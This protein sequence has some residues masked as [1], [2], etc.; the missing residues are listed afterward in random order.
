MRQSN[1]L[2]ISADRARRD[3]Q[4][5]I[6]RRPM[7]CSSIL[8]SCKI[9]HALTIRQAVLQLAGPA[10]STVENRWNAPDRNKKPPGL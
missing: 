5:P 7:L 6:T 1:S 2:G 3:C 9:I 10:Y 8:I 4:W